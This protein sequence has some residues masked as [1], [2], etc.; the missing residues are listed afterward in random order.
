M[1]LEQNPEGDLAYIPMPQEGENNNG[2][3]G[4]IATW[5]ASLEI[6]EFR[7]SP[8]REAGRQQWFAHQDQQVHENLAQAIKE[9]RQDITLDAILKSQQMKTPAELSEDEMRSGQCEICQENLWPSDAVAASAPDMIVRIACDK[10]CIYHRICI[11][12]TLIDN[13]QCP[14]CS[15]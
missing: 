6:D 7:S 11:I 12:Q 9:G 15:S 14:K 1:P 13:P 8:K 2:Q 5:I 3:D 10:G 4:D